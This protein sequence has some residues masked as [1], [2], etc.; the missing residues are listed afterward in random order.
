[1]AFLPAASGVVDDDEPA[2]M[3]ADHI[4]PIDGLNF[5][6]LN[7]TDQQLDTIQRAIVDAMSRGYAGSRPRA[8]EDALASI[9]HQ[10]LG[11]ME[12]QDIGMP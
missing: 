8:T 10:Y 2:T 3:K 5:M 7:M 12:W 9:C 11:A 1:M 4:G 6:S